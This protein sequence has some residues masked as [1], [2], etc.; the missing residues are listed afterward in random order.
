MPGV[1]AS[2]SGGG[3]RA[4]SAHFLRAG[5]SGTGSQ[6]AQGNLYGTTLYG[7][8]GGCVEANLTGCGVVFRLTRYGGNF[9]VN[10][11]Y[12]FQGGH[13]GAGPQGIVMDA[14]GNIFGLTGYGGRGDCLSGLGCGTL[15]ELT[16]TQSGFWDETVLYRFTGGTDGGVP[17]GYPLKDA[18]GNLYGVTY[19]GG[20]VDG[21]CADGC[22]T[23]FALERRSMRW[24]ETVIY[25]FLGLT[26]GAFPSAG[27]TS[28]KLGNLYGTTYFLGLYGYGTVFELSRS[29][30]TWIQS[31][32]WALGNGSDGQF[33][34]SNVVFDSAGNL[35][36]TTIQGGEYGWGTVFELTPSA[37]GNWTE[38]LLHSFLLGAN[39]G[40]SP[41]AGVTLAADG[42]VYG[43]TVQGG[44]DGDGTVFEL[45]PSSGGVW[46]ETILFNG[47]SY[48]IGPTTSLLEKRGHLI[49]ATQAGGSGGS[50][51]GCV[52]EVTP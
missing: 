24:Q 45:T 1:H 2:R 39:D 44:A 13:D 43:T 52:F 6:D 33:P 40:N 23:V 51:V 15:F 22:G 18:H 27:L 47:N 14:E 50:N 37:D 8:S 11:L 32:L 7:G 9:V 17:V 28:D 20:V 30:G 41:F 31:T 42:T 26:D 4:D 12:N 35:Y 3:A 19:Q 34:D 36:G 16:P 5:W 21:K 25:D 48:A 10:V 38:S 29:G 46:T 49:G